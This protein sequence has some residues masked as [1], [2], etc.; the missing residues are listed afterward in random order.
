[1]KSLEDLN[2]LLAP[3]ITE[4][5]KE[6]TIIS[7][8]T[9]DTMTRLA[10]VRANRPDPGNRDENQ[11]R[12]VLGLGRLPD[13]LSDP[14]EIEK[15]RIELTIRRNKMPI[16]CDAVQKQKDI[17][18]KL[19]CEEVAPDHT[20]HVKDVNKNLSGLH[21]SLTRYFDFLNNVENTGASTTA[22]SPIFP[23][24]LH[25]RDTSGIFHWTFKEMRENGHISMREIPEAVR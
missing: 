22:L 17:A 9:A 15:N 18:S 21:G 1:M 10:R 11:R 24:G 5:D 3:A 19:L 2:P 4:R 23:T 12:E 20:A 14:E 6:S 7:A 8:L 25:P 13:V 16:L